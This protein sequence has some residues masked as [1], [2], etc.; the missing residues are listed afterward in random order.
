MSARRRALL[1]GIASCVLL[2]GIAGCAQGRDYT[3]S[4]KICGEEINADLL[5][6]L[7]PTG[8]KV[9]VTGGTSDGNRQSCKLSVQREEDGTYETAVWV[10][11][12]IVP[13]GTDPIE[14][15]RE[16]LY[17]YGNPRKV[18]IGDDARL[19]DQG[20]LAVESCPGRG[21]GST[22]AVEIYLGIKTPE[23]LSD[24]HAALKRFTQDYLDRVLREQKCAA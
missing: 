4:D 20:V 1:S 24:R 19:A 22:L 9:S 11:W 16:T 21:R 18:A 10:R 15:K 12:D 13:A 5:S 2:L 3:V 8:T 23:K 7:M 17:G 6:P 14:V